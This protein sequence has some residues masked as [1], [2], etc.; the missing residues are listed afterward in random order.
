MYIS[1]TIIGI[2]VILI[3]AISLFRQSSEIVHRFPEPKF[4]PK[5][6]KQYY[7]RCK[8][9]LHPY[10]SLDFARDI[11]RSAEKQLRLDYKTSKNLSEDLAYYDYYRDFAALCTPSRPHHTSRAWAILYLHNALKRNPWSCTISPSESERLAYLDLKKHIDN[12]YADIVA[13]GTH[14]PVSFIDAFSD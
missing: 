5:G 11:L 12:L 9:F 8:D 7:D 4:M 13:D 10:L 1:I 14:C 2:I 3:I 6:T